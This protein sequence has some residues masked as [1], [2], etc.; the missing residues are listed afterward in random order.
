[1]VPSKDKADLWEISG[2]VEVRET[3]R[4]VEGLLVSAFDKDLAFD[5]HLGHTGGAAARRDL[6]Q[7]DDTVLVRAGPDVDAAVD[8]PLA[9]GWRTGGASHEDWIAAS[10]NPG[11]WVAIHR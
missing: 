10:E 1:M 4:P 6:P 5:D 3:R 8:E 9:V 11:R 7:V 2:T